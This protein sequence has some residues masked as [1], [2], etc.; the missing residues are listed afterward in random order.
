M[1]VLTHE[2]AQGDSARVLNDSIRVSGLLGTTPGFEFPFGTMN[3]FFLIGEMIVHSSSYQKIGVDREIS[4]V[5]KAE[6]GVAAMRT[7][8]RNMAWL[9]K[10]LAAAKGD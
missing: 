2:G 4:E 1:F 6:E 9:M 8:G 3:H 10:V 7:I 5:E